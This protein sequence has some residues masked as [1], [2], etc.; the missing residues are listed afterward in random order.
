MVYDSYEVIR[1]PEEQKKEKRSVVFK[2]GKEKLKK[3]R[4]R[5]NLEKRGSDEEYNE[6]LLEVMESLE[7]ARRRATK[8]LLN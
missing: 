6:H 3:A 2:P 5:L 7:P 1:M 8:C 4:E